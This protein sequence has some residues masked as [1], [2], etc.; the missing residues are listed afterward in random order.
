MGIGVS[1]FT[2]IVGAGPSKNCDILG[3]AMFDSAEIR[4]H[5]TGRVAGTDGF[6]EPGS[7]A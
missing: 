6:E 1:F 5:P 3:I 2:E 4:I 7:G